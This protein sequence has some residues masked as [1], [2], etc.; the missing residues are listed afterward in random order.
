MSRWRNCWAWAS[1]SFRYFQGAKV[2]LVCVVTVAC[3]IFPGILDI[4]QVYPDE[5][6]DYEELAREAVMKGV[7]TFWLEPG[8]TATK[9]VQDILVGGRVHLV[10]YENL[11]YEYLK[12]VPS[13]TGA[14]AHR[15]RIGKRSK[16]KTG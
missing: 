4:V 10:E 3:A 16:S 8:L 14:T 2:C 7:N 9:E 6:I 13:G 1:K 12:H 11:H 15:G 5:Q